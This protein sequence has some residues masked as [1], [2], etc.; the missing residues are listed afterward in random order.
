MNPA[1]EPAGLAVGDAGGRV[2]GEI[3]LIGMALG[4]LG[5]WP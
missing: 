1:G 5:I 3:G 4:I 2:D